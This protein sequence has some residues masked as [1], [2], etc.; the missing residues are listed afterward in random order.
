MTMRIWVIGGVAA[1]VALVAVGAI[2]LVM[3]SG[4]AIYRPG[5]LAAKAA[6]GI[7]KLEPFGKLAIGARRADG[8]D[9]FTLEAEKGIALAGFRRGE[10]KPVIVIFGGPGYPS[11]EGW[12]GL[13]PF[14][15]KRSFYYYH[16]RGSG[17]STRPVDR[18]ATGNYPAKVAEL[19]AKLGLAQQIADV[20]RLR[21]AIGVERIDLVGHSFGGFIAVLYAV[22]FPEHAGKLLLVAP[23]EVVVMPPKDGGLYEH[24]RALLG[25]ED[26]KAYAAW[27]GRFFDYG[28][29]FSR[30]EEDLRQINAGFIP[31]Y[32]AAT[33][34]K[35]TLDESIDRTD[36]ALI[37]GWMTHAIFFSMGQRHDWSSALSRIASPAT[38]VYGSSDT[39]GSAMFDQYKGLPGLMTLEIPGGDHFVAYDLERFSKAVGP[40][41]E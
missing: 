41:F 5:D 14:E 1:L 9:E 33:A 34:S 25:S 11:N 29:M 4:T 6:A 37:G 26:R 8:A 21:R 31:F 10:G 13:G 27:L 36:P 18:F 38:M 30:S 28:R 3:N 24:V 35:G 2:M 40:F 23:A 39:G 22:E 12:P 19:V 16:Q 17:L 20:E 15:A 32:R 7:V